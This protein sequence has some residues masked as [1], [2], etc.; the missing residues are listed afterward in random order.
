M[1]ALAL[2]LYLGGFLAHF[3]RNPTEVERCASERV[4]LSIRH[5]FASWLAGGAVLR[6]WA[7]SVSGDLAKGIAWIEDGMRDYVTSG[8]TVHMPYLL[9]VKAETLH[10]ADRTPEALVAIREAE[11][12][13][14][15]SEVRWWCAELHRLQGV[16]LAAMGVDEGSIEAAFCA[17][18]RIASEQ[19]SRSLATRAEASYAEYRG[20][21][22]KS[23][24]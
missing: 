23:R 12:L 15:S 21:A 1:H 13:V 7:C 10:L 9:A 3:E 14:E 2:A 20:R 17:A 8:A 22:E 16:F 18:I 5:H 24:G 19:K 11:A 6:G 4:E